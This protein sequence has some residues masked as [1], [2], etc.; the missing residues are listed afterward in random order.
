[1]GSSAALSS[2][3]PTPR[4]PAALSPHARLLRTLPGPLPHTTPFLGPPGLPYLVLPS[5][6]TPEISFTPCLSLTS[7]HPSHPSAAEPQGGPRAPSSQQS[8]PAPAA[9]GPRSRAAAMHI[10]ESLQDLADSEAVQFLKR[11]KTITRIFA[12]VRPPCG[13]TA[14]WVTGN[15]RSLLSDTAQGVGDRRGQMGER[16]QKGA[17]NWSPFT[18]HLTVGPALHYSENLLLS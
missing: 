8:A 12:G 2:C 1:M 7:H 16:T 6:G 4:T 5:P 10:P 11:P 3:T 9:Q 13:P 15:R 17:N 18:Q 14:P